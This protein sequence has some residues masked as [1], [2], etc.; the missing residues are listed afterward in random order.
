MPITPHWFLPLKDTP[1]RWI[2][3]RFPAPT[4]RNQLA[5]FHAEL[6]PPPGTRRIQL[7]LSAEGRYTLWLNDEREPLGRGPAR[8]DPLHRSLDPYELESDGPA[9]P[10]HL[11]AQVRYLPAP[12]EAPTAE[13]PGPTPGLLAII[14]FLDE[15]DRLLA[16]AGTDNSWQAFPAGAP[17]FLPLPQTAAFF[18][19]GLPERHRSALY[20][21]DWR[22]SKSPTD[23]RWQSPALFDP[24]YFKADPAAPAGPNARPWLT[25]REITF[26]EERPVFPRHTLRLE[27]NTWKD[28]DT[29]H[30]HLAP[31]ESA[32]L[33][34]DMGEHVNA[35]YRLHL[36]GAG[37]H[38]KITASEVLLTQ[39]T[40]PKK[41][42]SLDT[43]NTTLLPL[44]DEFL[45]DPTPAGGPTDFTFDAPHWRS[46]RF[47]ELTLHAGP[48]G[49]ELATLELLAT[50]Y[51][52]T[53][54]FSLELLPNAPPTDPSP[55]SPGPA[56]PQSLSAT[57]Q[58]IID[59]SW[60]TLKNCTWE[61]YMDCPYY[62][63]LQY[64]GDARIQCLLTYLT[65]GGGGDLT[66]PV[67][68]LRAFDRSRL[69]EGLT[70]SRYPS[71][72]P[73]II[74]TF[75]LIYI[76]ML[77][78]YLEHAGDDALVAELRPGIAPILNWFTQFTD[79][80]TG[81]IGYIPYWPFLDWVNGWHNGIPP[82]APDAPSAPGKIPPYTGTSA[83]INLLYL[84]A[85]QSATR[86]YDRAKPGSGNF[87][88]SR[89]A[90]LKQRIFDTFFDPRKGLLADIPIAQHRGK[91][92][93]Y[94]QH[95]QA[96]AILADLLSPSDARR[97]L[98]TALDPANVL[99][100]NETVPWGGGGEKES[101]Q[102]HESRFIAPASLYFLFYV[103]EALAKLRMGDL[104]WPLLAPFRT[105]L[106]RGSTT[107][108]ESFEPARSE[109]H[110][111]SAW[112]LYFLARHALGIAPPS[113]EDN[114]LRLRPLHCPPLNHLK[115]H[116]QTHQG[117]LHVNVNWQNGKRQI[118]ATG[119]SH[120]I[121]AD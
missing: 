114:R 113:L 42:F 23:P 121:L 85:L 55:Q 64:I 82:H 98:T 96:L 100:P 21:P 120:E 73:Q 94:S 15:S 40:P 7:H 80:D 119:P 59:T 77:E 12:P 83:N 11:W 118:Q 43:P 99:W 41:S 32:T 56:A 25:Q 111:W 69:P 17:E 102:S 9:K 13:I 108:P 46:F 76:L 5:L 33:R 44:T 63:Q 39:S 93:I 37:T 18:A 31:N 14:R 74:P 116:F 54:D 3:P 81:L 48:H 106:S 6:L 62:E 29:H 89:A 4:P 90:A 86:I 45:L 26:P 53:P 117:P 67:Q 49:G 91:P 92:G 66:L 57:L 79:T 110:A 84:L 58:K 50:N 65:T 20:P 27:N 72:S 2:W 61:T 115:G 104:L 88:N 30:L 95:A 60:R 34:L 87:Y 35:Y 47:L 97:A 71:S 38:C 36:K 112:P 70:Q 16:T 103:A 68:A 105:A 101:P 22:K 75:S 19:I 24:P 28:T 8:T 1:A 109:C 51:P 107:W 52:L 10:L 78:D